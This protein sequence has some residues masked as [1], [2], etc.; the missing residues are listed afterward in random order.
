MKLN[1]IFE[2]SS[3]RR[4]RTARTPLILTA[5]LAVLLLFS[6]SQLSMFF[7]QG[8]TVSAMRKS[9]EGY[10][11]LTALEFFLIVL[12]APA[13]SAVS[14]AGERER[15][16][17]DLLL[18][19]GVGARRIVLGKLT[20]NFAFLA[21]MILCG[22][23]VMSL[24]YVTGG[25]PM[26][27]ILVTTL[28]L[29]VIALE[30]LSVGMVFSALCSRSLT[31][32]ISAYLAIVALGAG[33]WLLS[34]QGPLAAQYTPASLGALADMSTPSVL[35]GMPLPVFFC[36]AVGLVTLLAHQTGILHNTM[37]NTM[38]LYDIYTAAKAAGFGAVSCAGFAASALSAL[39]MTALA[40]AIV[41][42]RTGAAKRR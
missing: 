35:L 5:W 21:L 17:F 20:E 22:V 6:L 41:Q 7:G 26:T 23:P 24:A 40:A 29:L 18:V 16:T 10:I 33:S 11:W 34:K 37:Q 3:L 15:Q 27:D 39:V 31:A 4:M 25:V 36:P 14:I 9:T 32:I 38:R 2:S 30:A 42:L 13:L 28:W 8:V 12:T 1:P 19:T